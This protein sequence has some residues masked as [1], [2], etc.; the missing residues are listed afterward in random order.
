[1]QRNDTGHTARLSK[2]LFFL[3]AA[4][5]LGALAS[6]TPENPN[7]HRDVFPAEEAELMGLVERYRDVVL[8]GSIANVFTTPA[9]L[10]TLLEEY[11]NLYIDFFAGFTVFNPES[12]HSLDEF[13]PLVE[14]HP[15]RFMVSTD[16]GIEIGCVRAYLAMYRLLERVTPEAREWIAHRTIES[17]LRQR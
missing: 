10:D 3:I 1:M 11:D 9:L 6:C 8:F 7:L 2:M 14:R 15:D 12:T 13:L 17:L 5:V 16:S 4:L